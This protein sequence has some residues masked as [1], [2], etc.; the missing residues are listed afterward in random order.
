MHETNTAG[1]SAGVDLLLLVTL[2]IIL[3][4]GT[5]RCIISQLHYSPNILTCLLRIYVKSAVVHSD[6]RDRRPWR[7]LFKV[8]TKNCLTVELLV[9]RRSN[10]H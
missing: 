2:F 5:V 8:L 4:P 7:Q 6:V 10:R 3:P 9:Y 1:V